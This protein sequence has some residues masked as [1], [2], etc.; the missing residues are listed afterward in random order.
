MTAD[1]KFISPGAW[2]EMSYPAAWSEFEDTDESFLFYN[3][4]HWT[5]NFRIS[6]F[7]GRGA[8]AQEA[9]QRELA[10]NPKAVARRVGP[11]P[12]AYSREDFTEDGGDYTVH[13]WVTGVDDLSFE[14]SFTTLRD[15]PA[16]EAL[17][18]LASLQVRHPERK[19]PPELI[20][21]RL[22]EIYQINAAYEWVERQV[23]ERLKTDFQGREE[24]VAHVQQLVE[25]A[26]FGP[27][28]REVWIDLGIVLC[29]ILANEVD[30]WEWRTL[31]DGNR[32]APVLL[33]P[34]TGRI[35][36]PLKLFWS[37]VR[38][39]QACRPEDVYR[40]LLDSL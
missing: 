21:V 36:D 26:A 10:E 13:F 2:F 24:D 19:Y 32:E 39:G 37:R 7:R 16:D 14:C 18:V 40:E 3:P 11:W 38:A 34:S 17:Q 25:Q 12:C 31:V 9:L 20:Q 23:K 30:G 27:R 1:K 28:K 5:G 6:A 35:V 15:A 29:V 8:F 33:Q 4:D 22:S